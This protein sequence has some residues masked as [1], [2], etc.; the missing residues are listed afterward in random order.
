MKLS[1]IY[2]IL[3]LLYKECQ[4]SFFKIRGI[5]L[6]M[7]LFFPTIGL[8]WGYHTSLFFLLI[9]LILFVHEFGHLWMMKKLK[10]HQLSMEYY[11][12]FAVAKGIK[13]KEKPEEKLK[14]LLAG[15]VPGIF[16]GFFI[17]IVSSLDDI[18]YLKFI[19]RLFIVI[20]AFNLL[21]IFLFD[22][23]QIAEI[24]FFSKPKPKIYFLVFS[25]L[26]LIGL[27]F[28]FLDIMLLFLAVIIAYQLWEIYSEW[29]ESPKCRRRKNQTTDTMQNMD[30]VIKLKYMIYWGVS[31]IVPLVYLLS[32]QL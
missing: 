13:E 5:D 11:V 30:F 12:G 9:A 16:I 18:S 7:M 8:Y 14:V 20:N 27:Q 21:P 26:V 1:K 10:Y 15:P 25:L 28:V 6:G 2:H 17:S 22:G 3:S 23:G 19:G 29:N 4:L 24:L 32:T 31:L